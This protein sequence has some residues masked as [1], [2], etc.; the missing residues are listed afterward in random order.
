MRKAIIVLAA[1]FTSSVF[2]EPLVTDAAVRWGDRL[3]AVGDSEAQVLRVTG[4]SPDLVTQ[5]ENEY[6]AGVGARWMFIRNEYDSRALYV[7]ISGG[8]V[9][10][11]WA[12][13]LR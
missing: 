9:Y 8:R 3:I 11:L 12:E 5:L 10:R 6:G 1:I 2:A 13:S 7:E 4:K